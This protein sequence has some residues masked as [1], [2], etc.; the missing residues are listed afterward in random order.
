MDG[1][2]RVYCLVDIV[3]LVGIIIGAVALRAML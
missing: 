3:L 2:T 1:P